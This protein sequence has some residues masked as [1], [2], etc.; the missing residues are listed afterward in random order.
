MWS[1]KKR[2]TAQYLTSLCR[3]RRV[4][5]TTDMWTSAAKRGY[6]VITLHVIDDE[7]DI[8][9]VIISFN[10]VFYPHTAERLAQNFVG[11]IKEC[12]AS[13]LPSIWAVTADNAS[14]NPA[15]VAI[16]NSGLL[17][18]SILA[19]P[20][21]LQDSDVFDT[22]PDSQAIQPPRMIWMVH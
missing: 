18:D 8:F 1:E 16:V 10:R 12:S 19:G 14:S 20:N 4:G 11:G 2:L 3:S 15:M 17:R 5:T 7:R 22:L 13:L 21:Q 6:M 9:N